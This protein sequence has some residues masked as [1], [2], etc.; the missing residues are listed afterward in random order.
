MPVTALLRDE[1]VLVT[2][3]VEVAVVVP[4]L[5]ETPLVELRVLAMDELRELPAT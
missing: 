2:P 4:E 1:T 5:R 3:R